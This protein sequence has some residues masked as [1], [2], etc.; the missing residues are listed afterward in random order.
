MGN[1]QQG[2]TSH[3][4]I[5]NT[6]NNESQQQKRNATLWTKNGRLPLSKQQT[7]ITKPSWVLARD[8]SMD[9]LSRKATKLSLKQGKRLLSRFFSFNF[10]MILK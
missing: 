7:T 6:S 5:N 9:M 10:Y 4:F 3:H 2:G 1:E 8:A